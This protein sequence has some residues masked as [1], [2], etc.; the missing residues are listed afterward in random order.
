MI[1]IDKNPK[2]FENENVGW[3]IGLHSLDG[4]GAG[5]FGTRLTALIF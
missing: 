1:F 3:F 2:Q 4:P 5:L